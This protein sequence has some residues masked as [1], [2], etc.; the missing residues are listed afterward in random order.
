MSRKFDYIIVGSGA[1]GA[2]LARELCRK[3]REVLI[4]EQGKNIFPLPFV[5]EKSLEGTDIFRWQQHRWHR[6]G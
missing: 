3:G 5:I 6:S 1:G 2:T 4:V